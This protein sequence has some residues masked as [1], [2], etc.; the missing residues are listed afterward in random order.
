MSNFIYKTLPDSGLGDR[1]L[2]LINVYVYSEL[3]GYKHFYVEWKYGSQFDTSRKCLKK[4]HLFNYIS[5]PENIIFITKKEMEQLKD[6]FIFDD[7]VGA[8]SLYSFMDKYV[9]ETSRHNYEKKYYDTC[10]RFSMKNIPE[11]VV[12]IFKSN[13]STVHLRRTDKIN[14]DKRC[15]G[16]EQKELD[17]LN[18]ITKEF[19]N[20]EIKYGNKICIISD[21]TVEK[22]KFLS[23]YSYNLIYFDLNEQVSQAYVDFYCLMYSKKIFL[24]QQFS[25]FSIVGSLL[26]KSKHLYYPYNYGRIYDYK[27][28]KLF[29]FYHFK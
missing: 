26:N 20:R 13:I 29:N 2:D 14:K 7:I 9:E 4:E 5:F 19:I 10:K 28:N 3:L 12:N 15:F 17:N 16:I 24:S 18:H 1:L 6:C 27:F 11:E 21:D 23:D 8:L 25:T 22:N